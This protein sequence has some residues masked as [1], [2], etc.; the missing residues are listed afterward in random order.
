MVT[1]S[2]LSLGVWTC[3]ILSLRTATPTTLLSTDNDFPAFTEISAA[4]RNHVNDKT[5][6][7]FTDDDLDYEDDFC[8]LCFH[9]GL[10]FCCE[11]PTDPPTT[12]PTITDNSLDDDDEEDH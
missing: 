8:D 2:W 12:T 11:L 9:E 1:V 6:S 10:V 7:G 4:L 5:G 3:V